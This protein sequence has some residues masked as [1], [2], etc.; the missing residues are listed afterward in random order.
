M[1]FEFRGKLCGWLCEDCSETLSGLTVRLYRN[2]A[3]Q[4]VTG[5]ATADPKT[6]LRLLSD[7][8]VRAKAKSLISETV[9]LAD[10]TFRFELGEAE[11]YQGDAFEV[12]VYCATVPHRKPS[13]VVPPALQFSITTLQPMWKVSDGYAR[14]YWEYCVPWRFW[15]DIRSKFGAWTIWGQVAVCG[16]SQQT[17]VAGVLVKAFDVDWTQ[18]DPLGSAVT[19]SSGHFR[20]DYLAIDFQRTPF[21]GLNIEL[22]GGP[23]LYFRVEGAGGGTLLAEPRSRGRDSDRAN[24][25][26]CFCA[27]LCVD[28]PA[29]LDHAWFTHV[30]DFDVSSDFDSMTGKTRWAAPVGMADAHGGPNFGFYD[31][32][33]GRGI[34]LV[35]DCPTL[36]PGGG[37]PMR[38]R[39]LYI[40]PSNP[41]VPVPITGARLS[42][43]IVGTRPVQWNFGAGL[44]ETFQSIVVAPTG[45]GVN[46]P[47]LPVPPTTAPWTPV[48]P[49]I[50]TPDPNG[51]VIVDPLVT[52]GALSGPLMQFISATAVPGGNAT[53]AGDS[54][55]NAPSD[56]K[57]GTAIAIVFEAEPVS[58]ATISAPTLTN[59]L[60]K[61]LI[62]NWTDVGLLDFP[63]FDTPGATCCTPLT[64]DLDIK[65]TVDHELL[66]SWSIGISSCASGSGWSPTPPP[67][68]AGVGARGAH[69]TDSRAIDSWPGCSYMVTL[70]TVRSVTDGT[71]DAPGETRYLTFCIDR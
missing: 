22:F 31:G 63:Q 6:T 10:G 14:A 16:R 18:D 19:D 23:D 1:N 67:F 21:P 41:G 33:N 29:I 48:P 55:G 11:K 7:D 46:P 64:S 5:L 49:A 52:N 43:V 39:F 32:N 2:R 9:T 68:P 66:G 42:A 57:N 27:S 30:G 53:S 12:D 25:G 60:A 45:G 15:C 40:H 51:W 59:S 36:Y 4:A 50:I 71:Q 70:N 61:I 44:V 28:Q 34:T 54:A 13:R 17:P 24:V 47:P 37:Q 69:G 62:N 35:G 38:Y 65:Y 58:G 56:P 8:E 3:D 26:P 20:I